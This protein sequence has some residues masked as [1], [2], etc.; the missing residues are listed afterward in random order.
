MTVLERRGLVATQGQSERM[1]PCGLSLQTG[2]F[3]IQRHRT[4]AAAGK[5]NQRKEEEEE[6]GGQGNMDVVPG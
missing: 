5:F 2:L 3:L 6:G 4:M 1:E